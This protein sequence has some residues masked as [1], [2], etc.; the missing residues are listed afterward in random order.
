MLERIREPEVIEDRLHSIQYS[1]MD[2]STVNKRFVDDM[3]AIG[4]VEGR[5]LDL[6]TG[7]AHIPILICR[8]TE[9]CS[10]MACDLAVT[11]LDVA[12]LNIALAG[13]ETRIQLYHGDV[14]ALD[15]QDDECDWVISNSLIHH[16]PDPASTIGH[17]LRVLRP[18]GRVFFRD[19]VRPDN[20]SELENLVQ[21]H[22]ADE[23]PENQQLLR[24]SL[25]ASLTLDEVQ[26]LVVARGFPA[27][28]VRMT[29]DRHWTWTSVKPIQNTST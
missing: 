3:L 8:A 9:E 27:D 2:H 16:L 22:A 26:Q 13:F 12:K 1:E 18:G 6:G 10:V 4:K 15:C 19:L 23:P 28:S 7:P 17:A 20:Q 21:L 24:Q 29:S 11:M 5:I 25:A 14:K